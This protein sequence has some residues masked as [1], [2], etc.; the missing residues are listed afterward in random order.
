L[1]KE[2]SL[3]AREQYSTRNIQVSRVAIPQSIASN[4]DKGFPKDVAT[5]DK[6]GMVR[7]HEERESEREREKISGL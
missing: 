3:E 1:I 7:Q 4:A 6:V 2:T 5:L